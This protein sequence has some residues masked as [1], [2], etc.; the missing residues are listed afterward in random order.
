MSTQGALDVRASGKALTSLICAIIS[1][2]VPYLWFVLAIVAIFVGNA[3]RK[4]ISQSGGRLSGDGK[5]KAG[6]IIGFISLVLGLIATIVF[7]TTVF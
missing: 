5:A 1:L 3:A 6:V 4:E 7:H 2:V